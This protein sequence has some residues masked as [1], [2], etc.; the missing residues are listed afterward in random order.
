MIH[1][2]LYSTEGESY[3]YESPMS[4]SYSKRIVSVID[5]S[6]A[7]QVT[8]SQESQGLGHKDHHMM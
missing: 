4:Q 6:V 2:S 1:G 8:T 7:V 3:R 5:K